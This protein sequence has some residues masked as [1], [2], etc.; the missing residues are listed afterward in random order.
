MI[1]SLATYNIRARRPGGDWRNLDE[2]VRVIARCAADIVALQEIDS[3]L[4]R[5][6]GIDQV[7]LIAGALG[8]NA[9]P[10]P[11]GSENQ[12]PYGNAILSRHP[13]RL[14][15][16]ERLP[17]LPNYHFTPRNALWVEVLIGNEA[18]QIINAHLGHHSRERVTQ[19][20]ALLGA[21]WI[22][23]PRCRP[24]FVLCGDLN[25]A[26]HSEAYRLLSREL[27][28]AQCQSGNGKPGKTWPSRFPLRRIDHV[29]ISRDL[30]VRKISI[31]RDPLTRRASDH[32]PLVVELGIRD[33]GG[34]NSR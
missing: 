22:R 27:H 19:A 11:P 13:M 16:A 33:A 15:R 2:V 30:L 24:P 14:I 23:D 1:F 6:R 4:F 25:A 17:G 12:G 26:P 31:P 7:R 34:G 9:E 29:F 28:D 18:V 10:D 3:S 5:T 32:L 20:K 8:I 21:D